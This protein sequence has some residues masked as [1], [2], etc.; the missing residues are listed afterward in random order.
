MQDYQYTNCK[1]SNPILQPGQQTVNFNGFAWSAKGMM[2]Q[3]TD[4]TNDGQD[5]Q[6][7]LGTQQ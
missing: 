1:I 7:W 4:N 6:S 2:H 5:W 3:V